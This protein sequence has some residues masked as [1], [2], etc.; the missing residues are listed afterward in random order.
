MVE[1]KW[2][3]IYYEL[4]AKGRKEQTWKKRLFRGSILGVK[5]WSLGTVAVMDYFFRY[6]TQPRSLAQIWKGMELAIT[7]K[8]MLGAIAVLKRKGYIK[9]AY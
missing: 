1:S 5:S 3:E 7:K 6:K 4:T 2:Q 9:R 8:R